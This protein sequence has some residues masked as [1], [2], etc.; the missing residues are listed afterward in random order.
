MLADSETMSLSGSQV[1]FSSG[2]SPT[3]ISE[4]TRLYSASDG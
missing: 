4:T 1:M 3:R 2:G